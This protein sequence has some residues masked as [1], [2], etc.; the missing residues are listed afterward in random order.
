M[1]KKAVNRGLWVL[2]FLLVMGLLVWAN[3]MQ[4]NSHCTDIQVKMRNVDYTSLV[5]PED[6]RSDVL[7]NMP[8]LIGQSFKNVEL[9]SLERYVADNCQLSDVKAY[10]NL[11]GLINLRITPREALL[12]VYDDKGN[13][14]YLGNGKILMDHSLLKSQRIIVASGHIPHLT[15]AERKQVLKGQMDLPPIYDHLYELTNKIHKDDF[16]SALIDQIY[17]TKK[18]ELILTPKVG[19]RKIYFGKAEDMDDKLFNLKAFYLE[20]KNKIDWQK[21]RS[22]NVKYRNQIVCSK[23]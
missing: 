16:L 7:E 11:N 20:G 1:M 13:N 19:V 8:A 3:I 12:R 4:A 6:I 9:E 14:L 22:I 2:A 23:K 10:L 15:R 17:V 21:Y 18:Q 5:S